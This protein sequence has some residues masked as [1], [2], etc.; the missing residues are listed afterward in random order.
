MYSC[1]QRVATEEKEC[2]TKFSFAQNTQSSSTQLKRQLME[3][4]SI[5]Y[6]RPELTEVILR[7]ETA[8]KR[9]D[10]Q[11]S[12]GKEAQLFTQQWQINCRSSD[13]I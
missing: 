5:I 4:P 13:H 12:G 2:V 6:R 3:L 11:D 7:T 10:G 8:C 1:K 9:P